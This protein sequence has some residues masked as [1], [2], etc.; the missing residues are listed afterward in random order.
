MISPAE[1]NWH[2]GPWTHAE[3]EL[4]SVLALTLSRLPGDDDDDAVDPIAAPLP[5]GA[6]ATNPTTFAHVCLPS[7]VRDGQSCPHEQR[8]TTAGTGAATAG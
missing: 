3:R 8:T 1:C 4:R 5:R 7:A 2:D 6:E